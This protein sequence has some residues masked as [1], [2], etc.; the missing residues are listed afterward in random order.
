MIKSNRDL[1]VLFKNQLMTEQ[2]FEEE[3]DWLNEILFT[4]ESPEQFCKAHELVDRN[5]ITFSNKKILKE[6]RRSRLRPFRF[7]LNKN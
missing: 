2:S 3:V 5:Q 7:L 1:L 4:A 6:L